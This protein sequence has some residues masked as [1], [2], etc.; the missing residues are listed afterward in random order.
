MSKLKKA[1]ASPTRSRTRRA[2]VRGRHRAQLVAGD[3]LEA[4]LARLREIA[5]GVERPPHAGQQRALRAAAAPPPP[6][7]GTACR[8]SSARRS[9][10]PRCRRGRRAAR[11]RA[12]RAGRLRAQLAE[13]DRVVAAEHERHDARRDERPSASAI[14]PAVRSAL[15]GVTS[16]SPQSATESAA[17]TSTSSAGWYGRS[18]DRARADRLG[19]EARA[20]PVAGGRVERDADGRDVDSAGSRHVRAARERAHARVARRLRG[21]GRAVASAARGGHPGLHRHARG[22][23]GA[24]ARAA[25][26]AAVRKDRL[27]VV[28]AS[29]P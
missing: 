8:G 2:V 11:A 10:G 15:P 1:G 12:G 17:N 5:G 14:W 19:A 9:T 21:V 7:A 25:Q 13:H 20:G 6:R 3:H 18:S 26:A 23:Q 28:P 4:H 29:R 22:A 16:R 27:D 24:V